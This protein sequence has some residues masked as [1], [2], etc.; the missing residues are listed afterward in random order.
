MWVAYEGARALV[1][2]WVG[3]DILSGDD[4]ERAVKQYLGSGEH[5]SALM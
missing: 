2:T 4:A 3:E 1:L 5:R